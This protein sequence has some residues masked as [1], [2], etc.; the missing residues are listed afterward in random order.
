MIEERKEHLKYLDKV[1]KLQKV[2]LC[3]WHKQVN[4]L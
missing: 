3:Q 1:I 2:I 4:R